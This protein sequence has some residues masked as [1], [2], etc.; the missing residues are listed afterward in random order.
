MNNRTLIFILT[1]NRLNLTQNTLYSLLKYNKKEMLDIL[2]VDN[3]SSDGTSEYLKSENYEVIENNK[4]EGIFRG[5]K[6]GW[7]EGVKRGYDFVLNL[8]N[9]FPCIAPVPFAVL[10]Q[11]LD[12]NTDVGLIRLNKKRDRKKN[13]V[14]KE[15]VRYEKPQSFGS[16][17]ISKCNY[18]ASFNPCL[19][20]S[21]IIP[22]LVDYDG[23]K[24]KERVI[25]N[26]LVKLNL[27]CAK[28]I[29]E[30]FLTQGDHKG[31]WLH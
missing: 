31:G 17:S 1:W 13:M 14:T 10:E 6:K 9:D 29:P 28:L 24:P 5:T 16:Y 30:P 12:N 15:P 20:K 18:H 7:M 21:S 11:Y 22:A 3:G 2:F 23:D 26:N 27:K 25:M 4:N 8:Q 19:I